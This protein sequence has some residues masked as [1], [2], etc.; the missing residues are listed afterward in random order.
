MKF[1]IDVSK[2]QGNFDFAKA[3]KENNIEFAIL[4]GNVITS[5]KGELLGDIMPSIFP[6]I[7]FWE[8]RSKLIELI[9]SSKFKL[10]KDKACED[11][12]NSL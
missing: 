1:G 9:F 7:L 8:V 6:V 3:K 10:I 5:F 4:K 12:V 2:W 11:V